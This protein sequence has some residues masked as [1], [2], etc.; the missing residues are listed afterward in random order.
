M[1]CLGLTKRFTRCKKNSHIGFCN[2]HKFQPIVLIIAFGSA[3]IWITDLFN[4]VGFDKKPIEYV[5]QKESGHENFEITTTS[6]NFPLINEI[7]NE[8]F[9]KVSFKNKSEKIL[10]NFNCKIYL[11]KRPNNFNRKDYTETKTIISSAI[12]IMPGLSY[13][14]RSDT[15]KLERPI[16]NKIGFYLI[17]QY[18]YNVDNNTRNVVDYFKVEHPKVGEVNDYFPDS[19]GYVIIDKYAKDII[20]IKCQ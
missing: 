3:F 9:I 7:D 4:S 11:V 1:R 12:K 18:S 13:S 16:K 2:N 17:I 10:T 15:L 5:Y 14:L 8:Y 6:L 19:L 20:K